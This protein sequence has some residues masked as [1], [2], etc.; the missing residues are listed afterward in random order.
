MRDCLYSVDIMNPI[1][2]FKTIGCRLNQA[3]TATITAHFTG[4]G[5]RVVPH[6]EATDVAVIHGC[7]ITGKADRD[8]LRALRQVRR[9][10]PDAII[11]LTGCP[12]ETRLKLQTEKGDDADLVIGQ[13]GKFALPALLHRLHPSR[14]PPPLQITENPPVLPVFE[15][16]RAFVK[17]QDGCDFR[18]AYCVVPE[19]RG[20]PVSRPIPE[21]V[22][23]VRRLADS[24]FKEIVL[25][26][27]N[28]GCYEDNGRRLV[29]LVRAVE[30]I[31][32]V[33]RIRLSSIEITTTENLIIDHMA[34]SGK[35][36]HFLHIPLQSGDDGILKTMGRRYD[37]ATFRQAIDYALNKIPDLGLGTDIIVGF[38]GESQPAFENT[39]RLVR[40]LPFSNLHVFPYSRRAG[41]RADGLADQVP[42]AVKKER[43]RILRE[44]GTRQRA[45]FAA[46]FIGK[47][48]EALIEH[49][50]K[51][52]AAHGWTG[53]YLEAVISGTSLRRGDRAPFTVAHTVEGQL[54][55]F[56]P[57]PARM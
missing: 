3:E 39:V 28:L 37:V 26:G 12:A 44:L 18:C 1:V 38:P 35:L 10:A 53:Q 32:A 56:K 54:H 29:D 7:A 49:V 50:D 6:G 31:P 21:I 36:C 19:T 41:T 48:V 27:A 14:F 51:A 4:A 43:V 13:A 55:N 23:E 46:G 52:G 17:V 5:Y 34:T 15:T 45:V 8:S 16:L 47:T 25:T 57:F 33:A 40:D 30:A 2:S 9:A 20:S 11:I 22:E 42:A 24:G